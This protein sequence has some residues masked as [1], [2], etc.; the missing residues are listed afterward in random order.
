VDKT[1]DIILPDASYA[2]FCRDT[3]TGIPVLLLHGFAEDGTVWDHQIDA[4]T[5]DAANTGLIEGIR[6]IIPD[7]PGSGRSSAPSTS[8]APSGFSA[9]SNSSA[10]SS[11]SAPSC[12][13]SIDD[14]AAVI[15]G[16]L[17]ELQLEKTILIGHSMGGYIALAFAALYPERLTAVGL[18]HSTAYPD[19]EEKK[20]TRR[21]A[22]EFIRA[23]GA[24]PF[25]RQSIPNLF[26]SNTREGR[27][28][29]VETAIAKYSGFA[30]DS[31]VAYYEAMIARP[32]RTAVLRQFKGPVLFIA[33]EDDTVI[34]VRQVI[35]QCYL[36]AI[37][38]LH[39]IPGAGHMAM[40]ENPKMS[41]RYLA[42]FIN[43]VSDYE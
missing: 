3:G 43:F 35:E 11:S 36:P 38:D 1:V 40:L 5:G 20:A 32:D 4:L 30:P 31:L 9:L 37:A 16:L 25:I 24:A 26:S 19:S 13:L 18:F 8:S 22:I 41:N 14:M 39:V 6:L 29:L 27:P 2:I 42:E 34:P 23:N 12:P 33:G 7:L 15:K 17:D 21:K 28:E 10:L